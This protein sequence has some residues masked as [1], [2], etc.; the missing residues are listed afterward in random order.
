M[1]TEAEIRKV[2]M[3]ALIDSLGLIEAERFMMSIS[4]DKLDYTN[5]RRNNLPAMSLDALARAANATMNE[6]QT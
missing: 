5:W 2:G 3:Q 1:R 6:S 4:R